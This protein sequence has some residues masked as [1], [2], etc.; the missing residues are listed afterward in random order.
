[1]HNQREAE[2][3]QTDRLAAVSRGPA[4]KLKT[5]AAIVQL[6]A[7][8]ACFSF[9][10]RDFASK[11]SRLFDFTEESKT[12]GLKVEALRTQSKEKSAVLRRTKEIAG[13]T[14]PKI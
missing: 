5:L 11:P 8:P 4:G 10:T 1:L 7:T 12:R 6:G 13:Y 3:P 9:T 2:Q 14:Q